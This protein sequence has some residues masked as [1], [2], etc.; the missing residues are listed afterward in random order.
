MAEIN[1]TYRTVYHLEI[2][3]ANGRK[4]IFL[5]NLQTCVLFIY[6]RLYTQILAFRLVFHMF[7]RS[8]LLT[9]VQR[10]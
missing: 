7:G 4:E 10:D 9:I 1:I 3:I 8:L 6:S 2:L 5:I